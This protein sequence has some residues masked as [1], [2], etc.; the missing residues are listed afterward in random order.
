MVADGR[1]EGGMGARPRAVGEEGLAPGRSR[2]RDRFKTSLGEELRRRSPGEDSEWPEVAGMGGGPRS[3]VGWDRKRRTRLE[4]P[5]PS[6]A[7][8]KASVSAVRRAAEPRPERPS[9][10]CRRAVRYCRQRR[11]RIS[12]SRS[13]EYSK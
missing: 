4:R 13:E 12:G 5:V 1:R 6:E 8:R 2:A 7:S 3:L 9:E 11:A 10:V